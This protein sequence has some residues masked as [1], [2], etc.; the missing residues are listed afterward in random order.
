MLW[1]RLR[2]MAAAITAQWPGGNSDLGPSAQYSAIIFLV[3]VRLLVSARAVSMS[4]GSYSPFASLG[5]PGGTNWFGALSA[6]DLIFFHWGVSAF[7]SVP[8]QGWP[9]SGSGTHSGC[10]CHGS[11]GVF[12][13]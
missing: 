12:G 9:G 1:P 13:W 8:V 7:C 3:S 6:N 5:G 4:A 10:Q 2:E 11:A